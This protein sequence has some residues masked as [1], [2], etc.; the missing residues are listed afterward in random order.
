[1]L[2]IVRAT[3]SEHSWCSQ[4]RASCPA[5]GQFMSNRALPDVQ[6]KGLHMHL[7]HCCPSLRSLFH[8]RYSSQAAGSPPPRTPAAPAATTLAA[9]PKP[10][11]LP[12]QSTRF[13][14]WFPTN[15]SNRHFYCPV[16]SCQQQF[17]FQHQAYAHYCHTDD[18]HHIVSA[19]NRLE[20]TPLNALNPA[21]RDR[22][23][24]CHTICR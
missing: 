11:P 9:S 2:N 12:V 24:C 20:H 14:S 4:S 16:A 23:H 6:W 22:I 13:I 7:K 5:C 1:M 3:L 10:L 15:N 18:H 21:R 17:D 19:R 8:A